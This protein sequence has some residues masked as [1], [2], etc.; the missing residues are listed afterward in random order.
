MNPFPER[1]L[2]PTTANRIPRSPG[3]DDLVARLLGHDIN[4][5]AFLMDEDLLAAAEARGFKNDLDRAFSISSANFPP[6]SSM[7]FSRL[8]RNRSR[9]R[10]PWP[11][12]LPTAKKMTA[13]ARRLDARGDFYRS[14]SSPP[15]RSTPRPLDGVLGCQPSGGCDSLV[16]WQ[17][18]KKI[19]LWI[20]F[21][22]PVVGIRIEAVRKLKQ[23]GFRV[24]NIA[25]DVPSNL[26]INSALDFAIFIQHR[27][28][29][30]KVILILTGSL[31]YRLS[32]GG[33]SHL[34]H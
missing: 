21:H 11:L 18:P 4:A 7:P 20:K 1:I 29:T 2:S 5:A 24:D 10:I 26:A 12:L 22:V 19:L 27:P 13:A 30:E 25:S 23:S 28:H 16:R 17:L 8:L 6:T 33:S 32:F 31:I 34:L 14:S 15:R 9:G 3:A